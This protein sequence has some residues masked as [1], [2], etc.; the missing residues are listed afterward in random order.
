[1]FLWIIIVMACVAITFL[2]VSFLVWKEMQ[3]KRVKS[4]EDDVV[5][6]SRKVLWGDKND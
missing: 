1:M 6:L 2:A 3:D 4:L 5:T